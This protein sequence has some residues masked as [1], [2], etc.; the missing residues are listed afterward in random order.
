MATSAGDFGCAVPA[1]EPPDIREREAVNCEPKIA[2]GIHKGKCTMASL[3]GTGTGNTDTLAMESD[4]SV[5]AD[6]VIW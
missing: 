6:P 1:V 4:V 5:N 3:M 2:M